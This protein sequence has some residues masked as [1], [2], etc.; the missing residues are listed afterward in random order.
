MRR[1][2]KARQP[3]GCRAFLAFMADAGET[4][5]KST[6]SGFKFACRKFGGHKPM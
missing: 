5:A 6:A 4:L 1:I 2:A 3:D